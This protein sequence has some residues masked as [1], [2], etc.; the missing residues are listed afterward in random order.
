M[1]SITKNTDALPVY[2][3]DYEYCKAF[4][5]VGSN[6]TI[7]QSFE[8]ENK[9]HLK[10]LTINYASLF[11]KFYKIDATFY[12]QILCKRISPKR[13]NRF[14]RLDIPANLQFSQ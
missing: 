4:L 2:S 8:S 12:S 7:E 3:W 9:K 6:Q 10:S 14:L 13:C 1:P 5:S 11:I